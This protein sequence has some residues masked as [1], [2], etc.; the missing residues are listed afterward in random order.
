MSEEGRDEVVLLVLSWWAW[1]AGRQVGWHAGREELDV[2]GRVSTDQRSYLSRGRLGWQM[3]S[4]SATLDG[5]TDGMETTAASSPIII[6]LMSCGR[7]C[8]LGHS[9]VSMGSD[10]SPPV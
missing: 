3:R 2:V 1:Q 4:P 8:C 9:Q 5:W 10:N 7:L 6:G